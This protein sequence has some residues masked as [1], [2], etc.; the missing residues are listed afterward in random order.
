VALDLASGTL[1]H[2]APEAAGVSDRAS[3]VTGLWFR[4]SIV[5]LLLLSAAWIW[6][7]LYW[8]K[9]YAAG[10]R[11]FFYQ[12]YFEPAVMIACG[13]GFVVAQ[14]QV[15]AMVPFLWRQ[16][17]R[18]SC[19]AIPADAKLG[20]DGL[21]QGT[22]RYLLFTVGIAW[23]VLGVSWSGL[24]PLFGLLFAA[25]ILTAYAIFRLG[26]SPPLAGLGAFALAGSSLHLAYLPV[27]RDYAKAP[28]TLILV[29]FLGVLVKCRLTREGMPGMPGTP[30]MLRVLAV[31][32]GYGAVLGIGYG[33]RTDFLANIPPF[34]VTVFGF[35]EGG[36]FHNFRLKASATALCALVFLAVAWPILSTVYRSGGCQWHVALAG[37]GRDFSSPLGLDQPLYELSR[38]YSDNY[39]YTTVTSYAGRVQPGVGHI[40]YCTPAYDA[41]TGRYLRDLA[42]RFPGD[43]IVRAYASVL[44]IVELPFTGRPVAHPEWAN[45]LFEDRPPEPLYGHG[46]GLVV[47]AAALALVTSVS[48]RIGL[49][50]VFF[51]LYF[52][53]YPTIQ[54][55]PRHH[56]HLEFMTWWAAGFLLQAGIGLFWP[57]LRPPPAISPSAVWRAGVVLAGCTIALALALWIARFYQQGAARSLL[58]SYVSAPKDAISIESLRAPVQ[59]IARPPHVTDPETAD[60]LEVDL[61]GWRCLDRSTVTFRY[62]P[63]TRRDFSRAFPVRRTQTHALT[64]IFMPVY[65]DFQAIDWSDMSPGCIDGVYRVRNP[66]QLSLLLETVLPPRWEHAALYQRLASVPGTR[67]S[68]S[69]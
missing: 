36:V 53:G 17:E 58:Q 4:R 6:G 62:N 28:F 22:W 23:R 15:P 41:A 57:R 21:Y 29:L 48:L 39:V 50:L 30:G 59:P 8:N 20:T 5:A 27:L 19:D 1:S 37:F 24:G 63:E 9:T 60:L 38:E 7:T 31:G 65:G 32:A 44:R 11:P 16:A 3:R 25:T 42:T 68:L 61:N 26:M 66:G 67:P 51:L 33:F 47:V 2:S 10:V 49:F 40:E 12:N 13:K 45:M 34:L 46:I 52:G 54:F 35:L 64:R 18:F 43:L 55:D 56:F 14:P 69:P